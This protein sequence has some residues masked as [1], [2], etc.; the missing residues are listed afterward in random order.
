MDLSGGHTIRDVSAYVSDNLGAETV[1]WV[2]DAKPVVVGE[3]LGK[4]GGRAEE[5][6]NLA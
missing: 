4:I 1:E 5:I 6:S 3:G 2:R